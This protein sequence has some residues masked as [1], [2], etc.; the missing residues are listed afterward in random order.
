MGIF[1][2][3]QDGASR[4]VILCKR[5]GA[6]RPVIGR[7]WHPMIYHQWNRW[8]FRLTGQLELFRYNLLGAVIATDPGKKD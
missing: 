7:L 4:P 8:V 1:S 3:K 5:N 2:S 6:S